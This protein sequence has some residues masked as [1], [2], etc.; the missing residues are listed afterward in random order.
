M[1]NLW[2]YI[3]SLAACLSGCHKNEGAKPAENPITTLLSEEAQTLKVVGY[4]TNSFQESGIVFSSSL[5]GKI[6]QLGSKLPDAG[7]YVVTLWDFDSGQLLLQ[8]TVE[9]EIPDSLSLASTDAVPL[10][11]DKKYVI[12][13]N[14]RSGSRSQGSFNQAFKASGGN[15]LPATKGSIT[16]HASRSGNGNIVAFPTSSNNELSTIYGFPEFTFI[17]D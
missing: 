13:I 14:N 2:M 12:S 9:Q 1:K 15:V 4:R 16:M 11:I 8:K 10:T 5:A 17:P 3:L 7:I 6:T